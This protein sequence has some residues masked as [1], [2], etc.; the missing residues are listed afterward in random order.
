VFDERRF[1]QVAREMYQLLTT[2]PDWLTTLVADPIWL[3][4]MT[5]GTL[6]LWDAARL[7]HAA[8]TAVRHDRQAIRVL[9]DYGQDLVEGL[10]KRYAATLVAARR[11]RPYGDYRALP[12]GNLLISMNDAGMSHLFTGVDR[13]IRTASAHE[14]FLVENDHVVLFDHGVE[15]ERL[16]APALADRIL[17]GAESIN[18]LGLGVLC[19]AIFA[20]VD[21]SQLVPRS[22][23]LGLTPTEAA[24]L[25]LSASGWQDIKA[26]YEEGVLRIE[27]VVSG[28]G[29]STS[30]AASLTPF[31]PD[32]CEEVIF[33]G[34][35]EDGPHVLRGPLG[36]VRRMQSLGDETARQLALIEVLKHWERDGEHIMSPAQMRKALAAYALQGAALSDPKQA[37]RALRQL[38]DAARRLGDNEIASEIGGVM[39]AFRDLIAGKLSPDVGGHLSQITAWASAKLPPLVF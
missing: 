5:S 36:V 18:A 33:N 6:S 26:D 39:G 1:W 24:S 27:G 3:A 21:V 2:N 19:A 30:Q 12:S 37:I 20:G 10:G 34:M 8:M 38:H 25:V 11:S 14:E 16:E 17:A 7:Q 31:L 4:D 9:L 32:S 22:E 13:A 35:A 23:A 29:M 28:D 15:V